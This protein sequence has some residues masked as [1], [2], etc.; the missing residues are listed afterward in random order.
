MPTMTSS[1]LTRY[2]PG[3]YGRR[4]RSGGVVL[5]LALV[6]LV[7]MTVS[8]VVA[9]RG[10]TASDMVSQNIRSQNLALQA[11]EIALRYCERQLMNSGTLNVF[12]LNNGAVRDEWRTASNWTDT[13]RVNTT[14]SSF[15]GST[16]TYATAPQCIV[17]RLSYDEMYGSIDMDQI[18]IRP[19]DRG[20]QPGSVFIFRITARG[21]SPD[22][23]RNS[24]GKS[25]SGSEAWV[26]STIRTIL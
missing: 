14:P 7:V 12:S 20:V 11:A 18:T 4:S 16:V 23:Q 19:E 10:A 8:S 15:L 9:M 26:Q 13:T 22:F 24:S 25:I 2:R 6:L 21:F 17:R 1:R 5:V 3:T